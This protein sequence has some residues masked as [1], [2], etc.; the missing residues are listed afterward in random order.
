MAHDRME[1]WASGK[2]GRR[3]RQGGRTCLGAGQVPEQGGPQD[4]EVRNR[5]KGTG[6]GGAEGRA[7]GR[8]GQDRTGQGRAGQ[9]IVA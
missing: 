2:A 9:G 7:E 8:T 5:A 1:S 4:T 3:V 6:Q